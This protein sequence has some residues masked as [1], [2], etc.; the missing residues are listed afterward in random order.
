M[1]SVAIQDRGSGRLDVADAIAG[2]RPSG[3]IASLLPEEKHVNNR[4]DRGSMHQGSGSESFSF[5]RLV[6]RPPNNLRI[7]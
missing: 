3:I 6:Y 1:D 2:D 5:R 7:L 4:Y